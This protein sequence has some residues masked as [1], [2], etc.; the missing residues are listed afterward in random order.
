MAV[1]T[2]GAAVEPPRRTGLVA[3]LRQIPAETVARVWVWSRVLGTALGVGA[4]AG[5]GQLG[6]AY[7]LGL[8]RFA[9]PF[10]TDGLWSA[11]LT[12]VAWFA[13]LA[14]LGG[15]AAGARAGRRYR[16]AGQ[17][18]SRIAVAAAAG[19]G[20]AVVLP[21]TAL[22]ADAAE[23]VGRESAL[24]ALEAALAGGLGV[25][26]GILAAAAALSVRLVAVSV[27]LL[28]AAVWLVALVSVVPSLAPT[29]DLPEVRLGVLDLPAAGGGG[30]TIAALTAPILALL[31]CGT[32]AAAARSRGLSP[33]QTAVASTAAP[34]LLALV[35]LVG[36]PGTGDRAV[37]AAPYAGALI[38]VAT[39]LLASLVIGVVRLPSASGGEPEP[40]SGLKP[41]E[42]AAAPVSPAPPESGLEPA[43]PAAGPVSPA[44]PEW[45][46]AG[47]PLSPP[48]G[49]PEPPSPP[50]PAAAAPPETPGATEP[51]AGTPPTPARRL[52]L[53]RLPGARRKAAQVEPPAAG[54]PVPLVP[55]VP[56]VPPTSPEPSAS[57]GPVESPSPAPPSGSAAPARPS[58]TATRP[59]D[60]P[61]STSPRR[62]GRRREEEQDEHVDW[63][64][65][66]SGKEESGEE[67]EQGRRRLRQDRD[68]RTTGQ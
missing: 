37:Q 57:A 44:P 43:K 27:T 60:P 46:A 29:A 48:P 41:A 3:A 31:I 9:R 39:G 67:P 11:Q 49:R 7:G 62:R 10:P 42:P 19:L 34:G 51:L 12:W 53:P 54:P 8:V 47:A 18:G 28:V 6:V 50:E 1:G 5:A 13:V 36:S 35:Y 64:S 58:P 56:P 23:L 65:S 24:P 33:L 25:V 20:A 32:V 40:A 21:L 26:V 38:A 63:I 59:E 17:L 68:P 45:P 15:A 16:L 52:K 55:L 2:A 30:S 22:P 4:L 14:G 66:L 61:G